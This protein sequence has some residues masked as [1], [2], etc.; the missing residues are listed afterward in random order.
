M[1]ATSGVENNLVRLLDLVCKLRSPEGCRW[2]REQTK[3]D[4]ARYLLEE[5]CEV[6]DAIENGS[7]ADRREELGDLLLQVL[8]H[9]EIESENKNFTID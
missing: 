3:E 2:D 5:A 6:I 1:K 7:A 9:S 8:L 4:I